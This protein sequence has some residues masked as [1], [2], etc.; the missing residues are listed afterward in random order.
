MIKRLP[1]SLMP[2]LCLALFAPAAF[3]Q[4]PPPSTASPA[5]AAAPVTSV[6]TGDFRK[7]GL[8]AEYFTYESSRMALER[9]ARRGVKAYASELVDAFRPAAQRLTAGASSFSSLPALPADPNAPIPPFVDARRAQMLNQL[10]NAN[11][12]EFDKLYLDMQVGMQRETLDLYATYTQSGDEP[13]L[14]FF[15]RE[16]IPSLQRRY[17]QAVRLAR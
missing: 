3:A 10:A 13:A 5:P 9:S 8:M 4:T 11:G 12:R 2:V 6:S 15:A 16:S 14:T 17:Q 1:A 7:F